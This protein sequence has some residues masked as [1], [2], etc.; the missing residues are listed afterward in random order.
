MPS[1]FGGIP[2]DDSPKSGSKFGGIPVES[3][4]LVMPD[5]SSAAGGTKRLLAQ[6]AEAR[7]NDPTYN[8]NFGERALM[9]TGRKLDQIGR[10]IGQTATSAADYFLSSNP[11]IGRIGGAGAAVKKSLADQHATEAE[12]RESDAPL[13]KRGGSRLFDGALT[14]AT[15]IGPGVALRGTSVSTAFLPRT[16]TGNVTQGGAIGATQPTVNEGERAGNTAFGSGAGFVGA[17]IP[18]AVGATGRTVRSAGEALTD[19]GAQRRAVRTIRD[20]A[21]DPAALMVRNPSQVPGVRRSL[22]DESLDPGVARL[23][24]QARGQG[25]GWAEMDSANNAFRSDALREFSGDA[26]ALRAAT[27]DRKAATDPLRNAAMADGGVDVAPVQGQLAEMIEKSA[28]RPT[29]QAP[30]LD[31]QASLAKAGDSVEGLYTSRQFIDDLLQGKVGG[32]RNYARAARADLLT[33][34]S[35]LDQ[36]IKAVSPNFGN[37]LDEFIARS[38]NVNRMQVGQAL[39]NR[40]SGGLDPVTGAYMLQP[41]KFG[42][43]V[44]NIDALAEKATGFKGATAERSLGPQAMATVNSVNDDLTRSASRLQRG[45]GGGSHTAS[46]TELGKRLALKALAVKVPGINLAVAFLDQQGAKRLVGAMDA[47]LQNPESYRQIASK[48]SASDQRLL[49]MALSRA[50]GSAGAIAPALTE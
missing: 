3:N 41:G 10:G 29:R 28:A 30:L 17:A 18:L 25:S 38:G 20:E 34:K 24:T 44:K 16:I 50:G 39:M 26:V 43:Q 40:G 7:R 45:S 4:A 11:T 31:A 9:L 27:R 2:V 32:D 42:A 14:A 49:E 47:V 48:L 13:M 5:G 23:E 36:Q 6:Q 21:S 46:Q 22:Y 8:T 19:A 35:T 37:Y 1:K 15:Y 12:R 33:V